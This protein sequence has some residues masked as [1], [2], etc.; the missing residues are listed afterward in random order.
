V[1]DSELAKAIDHAERLLSVAME[2]VGAANVELDQ[3][4]ARNPK[5]VGITLLCRTITNFRAA[6]RLVQQEAVMEARVLVRLMYENPLW[7]A[8][9]KERGSAFAQDMIEDEVFSRRSLAETTLRITGKHG[10][11]TDGADALELRDIARGLTKQFPKP[12]KLQA[13]KTA[14]G[15]VEL[16]YVEY[17]RLSLDAVH[18]SVTALAR[19]LTSEKTE[20]TVELVTS[21]VPIIAPKEVLSTVLHACRALTGAAVAANEL[22]GFT[23]ATSKLDAIMQ[24]FDANGWTQTK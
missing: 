8:V 2:V 1:V 22:L 16:A 6:V 13:G 11:N 7:L 5:V 24:E 4:W 21:V 3:T 12:S 9:L 15:P 17:L 23:A 19:H 18:C 20:N 10:G 14:E